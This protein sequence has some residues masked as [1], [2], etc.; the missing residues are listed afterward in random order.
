MEVIGAIL[1]KTKEACHERL[2]DILSDSKN[3]GHS[4]VRRLRR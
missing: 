2:T 3:A 1:F 4:L